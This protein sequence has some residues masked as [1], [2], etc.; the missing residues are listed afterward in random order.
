MYDQRGCCGQ[1]NQFNDCE[2][3]RLPAAKRQDS[4]KDAKYKRTLDK[5]W[6]PLL[7]NH[8]RHE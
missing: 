4:E 1:K 5:F 2:R 6:H 7:S 8:A 3:Y